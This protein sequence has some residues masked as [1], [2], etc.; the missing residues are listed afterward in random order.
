MTR[1]EDT[2]VANT[3]TEIP[4]EIG[5]ILTRRPEPKPD[6]LP[7]AVLMVVAWLRKPSRPTPSPEAQDAP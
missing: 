2:T 5:T 4:R 1:G 7:L 6:P 3:K